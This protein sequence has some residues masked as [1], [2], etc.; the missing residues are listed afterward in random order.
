MYNESQKMAFV[1]SRNQPTTKKFVTQIFNWFEPYENKWGMDLALQSAEV[2]QPVVNELSGLRSKS[3]E[4]LLIMLKEYVKWLKNNG[5]PY[6]RGIY[7]VQIDSIEKV[8]SQMISSPAHLVEVMKKVDTGLKK[9]DGS[10]IFRGFDSAELET[11]DIIYRVFLWMAFS[12]LYDAEAIQVKDSDVDLDKLVINFDGKKFKIYQE[13]KLDFE[14]AC[15]LTDFNYIHPHYETRRKRVDG[16]LIMRSMRSEE[17]DLMTIR[18]IVNK[19]L[20][21]KTEGDKSR[22]KS[23]LSYNKIYLSGV[24]YRMFEQERMGKKVD[25]A[26]LVARDM[27]NT[28][29]TMSATR[30]RNTIANKL[31]REYKADYERW[32]CAFDV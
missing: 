14:K 25:F 9:K 15:C 27:E 10:A 31:E 26:K 5:Y 21:P 8:R 16:N 23:K 19:K 28:E 11:V 6:S 12:G 29:Y 17:I 18:P 4:L 24:F 2:L 7:G 22:L 32:K 13:A 20:N 1:N 30:T 3:T